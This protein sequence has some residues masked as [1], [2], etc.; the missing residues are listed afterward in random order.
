MLFLNNG[1]F[2]WWSWW[3]C[4]R[5][6][7]SRGDTPQ[8]VLHVRVE[9]Y[10]WGVWVPG[11]QVQA[12]LDNARLLWRTQPPSYSTMSFISRL[13]LGCHHQTEFASVKSLLGVSMIS[14]IDHKP[15]GW[16]ISSYWPAPSSQKGL[17]SFCA[18]CV[19][20]TRGS[21][22]TLTFPLFPSSS[23]LHCDSSRIR[24]RRGPVAGRAGEEFLKVVLTS[25]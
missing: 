22:G 1:S 17:G 15:Q 13:G 3:L 18:H 23:L 19:I 25:P 11:L 10:L 16:D 8:V 24:V 12:W 5:P 2:T 14:F 21:R 6:G 20:A 7:C 4:S 9:P